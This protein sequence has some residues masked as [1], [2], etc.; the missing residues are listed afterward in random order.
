MPPLWK[1]AIP[2]AAALAIGAVLTGAASWSFRPSTLP[3][4]ITRF[5]FTVPQ[6][7]S[8]PTVAPV[9]A[10][11][12]DGT[13]MVYAANNRLYLRSMSELEA[14]PIPG[15]ET[16]QG[17][18]NPVFSPDGRSIAFWDPQENCGER[19]SGRDDLSGRR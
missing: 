14:R 3:P 8:F 5:P 1:R 7:Q 11:S 10:I 4:T 9:V 2:I 12:P 6:G 13:Q 15:T 16:A 17:V 19:R 18:F